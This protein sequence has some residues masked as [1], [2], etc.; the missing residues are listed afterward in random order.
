[1][2]RITKNISYQ[3]LSVAS[4]LTIPHYSNKNPSSKI[5]LSSIASTKK[6]YEK[7][8]PSNPIII[9]SIVLTYLSSKNTRRERIFFVND[10]YS[11]SII[12]SI[13]SNLQRSEF[14]K[15]SI[16]ATSVTS[17]QQLEEVFESTRKVSVQ[18]YGNLY[19]GSGGSWA[20]E[21]GREGGGCAAANDNLPAER[22]TGE[23]SK[24]QRATVL[25]LV[26][27]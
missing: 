4:F 10:I 18:S 11:N 20:G 3:L 7:K 8:F 19:S 1:M 23:T 14:K 2:Q 16:D 26:A 15:Y 6:N 24:Q 22:T 27:Q 12:P 25:T 13:Y 5:L 9:L 17:P 21:G